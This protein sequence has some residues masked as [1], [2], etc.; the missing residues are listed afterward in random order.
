[1]NKGSGTKPL[2]KFRPDDEVMRVENNSRRSSPMAATLR[3]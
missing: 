1:M 2:A 3:F